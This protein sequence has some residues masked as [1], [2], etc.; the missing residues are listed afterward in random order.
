VKH[1]LKGTEFNDEQLI[2]E[3]QVNKLIQEATSAITIC[4][5]WP[6]WCPFW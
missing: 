4:Q 1:K 2:V 3:K 6:G 5:S